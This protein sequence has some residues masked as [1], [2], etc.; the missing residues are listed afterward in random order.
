M[1]DAP[2]TRGARG[3]PLH[4]AAGHSYGSYLG[5][6]LATRHPDWLYA[7]IGV[8]QVANMPESERRGWRFAMDAARR[9]GNVEAIHELQSIAPY[10]EPGKSSPI[11]DT[12]V[13]RKWMTY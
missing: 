5:L 8:G 1:V 10:P 11:Q 7:Y 13:E 2:A 4:C 6:E 9:E 12:Y 3:L